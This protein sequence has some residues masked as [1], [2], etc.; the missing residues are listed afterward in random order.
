MTMKLQRG[1]QFLAGDVAVQLF[2]EH[3]VGGSYLE[4]VAEKCV[5]ARNVLVLREGPRPRVISSHE[6]WRNL[7]DA[8]ASTAE[9]ARRFVDVFGISFDDF[10]SVVDD[11]AASD[12]EGMTINLAPDGALAKALRLDSAQNDYLVGL[13]EGAQLRVSG[14]G[15][16]GVMATPSLGPDLLD[17][18]SKTDWERDRTEQET[19]ADFVVSDVTSRLF[20]RTNAAAAFEKLYQPRWQDAVA[21]ALVERFTVPMH[22]EVVETRPDG[23]VRFQDRDE[24]FRE[25]YFDDAACTLERASAS[26]RVRVRFDDRA[27]FA[28]RRVLIQGKE[29]RLL[30][31]A[32]SAVHKFEKRF[33]GTT[34]NEAR[35]QT[36]LCTGKDDDG[37]PLKVAALLYRLAKERGT[38]PADGRIRLEPQFIVLQKR[39]RSHLQFDS[40]EAVRAR[41]KALEVE[42]AAFLG[43]GR[44][45]PAALEKFAQR[46]TRQESFLVDA[47]ALLRKYGEQLASDTDGFILSADR[48]AIY[49]PD[50]RAT[51]PNEL[52]DVVGQVGRGLHLEA[53]WDAASSD[54]FE[55]ARQTIATRTAA[56]PT[57]A[58]RAELVADAAKLNDIVRTYLADVATAVSVMREAMLAAGLALDDRHLSKEDRAWEAM[59]A[60]R[61][62]YWRAS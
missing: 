39:R 61:P 45:W 5:A 51:P 60:A 20:A 56:A 41:R 37:Q 2:D 10:C 50:A 1:R 4:R 57:P 14:T 13:L 16:M 9:R 27:P 31:A 26:V 22:L 11:V 40:V 23:T 17:A 59:A 33:E 49:D 53:E 58:A 7:L 44:P 34:V 42:R 6:H 28:V 48:Y 21:M 54:P 36:L 18:A 3:G 12:E 47:A 38:L 52:D 8:Y 35:A 32:S 24:M 43:A 62:I 55:K 15:A 19:W 25:T 29:G 30:S 46:L